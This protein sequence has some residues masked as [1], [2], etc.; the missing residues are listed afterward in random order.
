MIVLTLLSVLAFIAIPSFTE[1]TRANRVQATAEELKAFLVAARTEALNNR[2]P[3]IVKITADE[4]EIRD[5]QDKKLRILEL[6]PQPQVTS[7]NS[8]T[9]LKYTA[10]GTAELGGR[11]ARFTVCYEQDTKNGHMISVQPSG[12][13]R[14]YP[15]GRNDSNATLSSCQ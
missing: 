6:D 5:N 2:A 12:A 7:L 11:P 14:L 3:V 10:N 15:K 4:W 8:L 9:E 1:F 13:V